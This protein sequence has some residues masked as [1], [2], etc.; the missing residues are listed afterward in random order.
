MTELFLCHCHLFASLPALVSSVLSIA[1]HLY[2]SFI[3][4]LYV[5][6]SCC[7]YLSWVT[8]KYNILFILWHFVTI[9]TWHN[10]PTVILLQQH[11]M[12]K[13]AVP[14]FLKQY[15]LVPNINKIFSHNNLKC[16]CSLCSKW[17]IKGLYFTS[18]HKISSNTMS[19]I[20]HLFF[21]WQTLSFLFACSYQRNRAF[22]I[23]FHTNVYIWYY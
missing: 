7:T 2:Y 13:L 15:Q 9:M 16:E 20:K 5:L 4:Q 14:I 23:C 17:K 1:K 8:V 10:I 22:Y 19:Q 12:G 3:L 6:A 21:W 11:Y 18:S